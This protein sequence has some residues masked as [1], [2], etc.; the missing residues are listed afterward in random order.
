MNRRRFMFNCASAILLSK[1]RLSAWG[2]FNDTTDAK[3]DGR[4]EAILGQPSDLARFGVLQS[5]ISPE[6]TRLIQ[7]SLG[8]GANARGVLKLFDFP[9]RDEQFDLGVE[10]P[11]F[12]TVDKVVLKFVADHTIPAN[13]FARVEYW[14]GLTTAQGEW[15]ALEDGKYLGV[16]IK[17]DGGT[18]EYSF[19]AIRTCKIRF[20]LQNQKQV[21]IANFEVYGPSRWKSGEVF[22]EWGHSKEEQSCDGWIESYNGEVA[23]VEAV[24]STTM[25]GPRQW[26]SVAGNGKVGGIV[27]SVLYTWG[28]DV[29]RTVLTVRCAAGDYSFLP[30]EILEDQ[31]I[32]IPDFGVYVR[33]NAVRLTA[34]EFRERN[35]EKHRIH[36]A[37]ERLPEQTLENARQHIH[38]RRVSLSFLGVD[39]N[40]QK[41]GIA[42]DGHLVVGYG[43]PS[44]GKALRAQ[45]GVFFDTTGDPMLFQKPTL[46]GKNLFQEEEAKHQ[47]LEEG[48][49]PIIVTKWSENDLTFERTDYAVL[50]GLSED[51]D[52]SRLRGDESASMISRLRIRNDSPV[53]QMVQYYVK[54]WKPAE[55]RSVKKYADVS[56]I[57]EYSP[58]SE[59]P[60]GAIPPDIQNAWTTILREDIAVVIDQGRELAICHF[61]THG[62][63]SLSLD[64]GMGAVKF[65]ELVRPGEQVSV[66]LVIP[67]TPVPLADAAQLR[68]LDYDHLHD[69]TVN[70]WKKLLAAGMNIEVPDSYMQNLFNASVHHFLLVQTKDAKRKENYPNTA[71]FRYGSI[72]SESSPIM[73]AMDM[74]GMHDRVRNCLRGWLSTQGD[75]KPEGAYF[76]KE[77]GFYNFWPNFTIDQGAV[78]WALAEHYL[79]TRDKRW[80]SAAAKQ[81]VDG[82]DF[83]IRERRRFMEQ[84]AGEKKPLHYGLAP[85]GCLADSRDWEYSFMLNGYFYLGLKKS[86][87]ALQDVDAKNAARIG[88]EAED[89]LQA[90]RRVLKE[91]TAISPVT[92]LRDNTGVPTVP[93]YLGLRGFSSDVK[94]SVDPDARHAYAYDSTLGPFHLVKSEVVE[95][96]SPEADWML[97]CLEDRFFMF[98]PPLLQSR[99]DLSELSTDWF[100]IGGFEKLQPYYVHYQ[101]AYLQRDEIQNFLRGFFNTLLTIADPMTL[102]F[103]EELDEDGGEPHKTHEE[104]WFF[105]QFRFMLV[106]E[107][108]NDL[109]L[110]RGTPREW[111]R[112]GERIVVNQASTYFGTLS[113]SIQSREKEGEIEAKVVP[114][115]R[116][117]PRTLYLRLRHPEK[118][119]IKHV[120]ID[121]RPWTR[122]DPQKEWIEVPV[123]AGEVAVIAKY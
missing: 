102:T 4:Y 25:R 51:L 72:G 10:W 60:Y 8:Y 11:E 106:M 7:K 63:G 13:A 5:W 62:R 80:L 54:P 123:D 28:M 46:V 109:F 39:A 42:P 104:A 37:V 112:H 57:P 43:D 33:N 14:K 35:A 53:P 101:D 49:L 118:A 23:K 50:A 91:C 1:R 36:D 12:R 18:W 84:S 20:L 96:D 94:D 76:S 79:Y 67:G 111:L 55:G 116:Q 41:F 122:F 113:Y 64:S 100:N 66:D 19:S 82:C 69:I 92:R 24:G 17:R 108:K 9:W 71:M 27:A 32:Y 61:E 56:L 47:E 16:P 97:N 87:I 117:A 38:A 29:D 48:W 107:M 90:I 58:P 74:L 86:A 22:I 121:G 93:S 52:E 30:G 65:S 40:N 59:M 114:P 2:A 44:F 73:Q 78:L 103:Q 31:P 88:A 34:T 75:S 105:H 6:S 68:R 70:Y 85:A 21:E 115:S 81:I 89:Y 120:T 83:I 95:P 99:I 77:G 119:M 45:F 26:S 98:T 15:R 110:A 3:H